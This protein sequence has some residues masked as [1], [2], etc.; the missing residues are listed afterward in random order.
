MKFAIC[1]LRRINTSAVCALKQLS[2]E[3]QRPVSADQPSARVKRKYCPSVFT[4]DKDIQMAELVLQHKR[5]WKLIS[6]IMALPLSAVIKRWFYEIK[7]TLL[8]YKRNNLSSTP[9]S[10]E[11][12]F[13]ALMAHR[14]AALRFLRDTARQTTPDG[15]L[16]IMAVGPVSEKRL[17]VKR[18]LPEWSESDEQQLIRNVRL[19]GR[20]WEM[21]AD[22]MPG[23]SCGDLYNK[24]DALVCREARKAVGLDR[25]QKRFFSKDDLDKFKLI[26]AQG[27]ALK[28]NNGFYNWLEI[29]KK[30]F[31]LLSPKTLSDYWKSNKTV[32]QISNPAAALQHLN[33][34]ESKSASISLRMPSK[35]ADE[36]F[37]KI[38]IGVEKYGA[39]YFLKHIQ[40]ELPSK[41]PEQWSVYWA[42]LEP[43]SQKNAIWTQQTDNLILE[44]IASNQ[45]FG[46]IRKTHL[47]FLFTKSIQARFL[48]L[49]HDFGKCE[50]LEFDYSVFENL[51]NVDPSLTKFTQIKQAW[52]YRTC[53]K[54][55]ISINTLKELFNQFTDKS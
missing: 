8:M 53:A 10:P 39:D 30:Y 20:K 9:S 22:M 23:R 52:V 6:Q 19:Y 31:P 41:S 21:I 1:A 25:Q 54:H 44:Q 50:P 17:I 33:L 36:E 18:V 24:Y 11:D 43:I 14:L 15:V 51:Q 55:H 27:D 3:V 35:I 32:L 40:S 26:M 45:T 13:H 49:L 7:P 37:G 42:H 2:T 28:H 29:Q 5:N 47:H 46:T 4:L 34:N 12:E 16:K 48:K 38:S